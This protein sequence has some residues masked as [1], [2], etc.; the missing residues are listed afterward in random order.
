MSG[1]LGKL[2]TN[3][4]QR[5]RK[6]SF[7]FYLWA[8]LAYALG[9]FLMTLLIKVAFSG[10]ELTQQAVHNGQRAVITIASGTVEGG[11]LPASNVVNPETH[12]Q[13]VKTLP[14]APQTPDKQG[15]MPVPLESLVEM[16]DKGALPIVGPDGT[17]PWKYYSRPA[18]VKAQ[19]PMVAIVF[20]NL[21]L[22]ESQTQ[23]VLKLPPEFT[24]G[25]SPYAN[26]SGKIAFRARRDGFESV[27]DLPIQTFDYPFSDPGMFGLMEDLSP[28]ENIRRLHQVL[29]QF[30]GY[31]GM[32]ASVGETMTSNKEEIKPYLVELKKRGLLFLYVKTQ[33]NSDL[34][35]F[36][37]INGFY[38]LGIDELIDA[39]PS[40][41][42][43][44][45]HLQTL[46]DTAK[47]QGYAVGLVHS[48]PPTTAA[49][50]AWVDSLQ[51]QGVVLVPVSTIA[52]KVLP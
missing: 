25:F 7:A 41:G 52:K 20:T 34:E 18:G 10:R 26:D 32:L 42:Y 5:P 23:D 16:T 33:K 51:G 38:T 39:T 15:M 17:Q 46:V 36:A 28:D 24:L 14:S 3:G 31:I 11:G 48:Y 43:I 44:E 12:T 30:P 37:K 2:R 13:P 19:L 6:F 8:A 4:T 45:N 40:K 47:K 29:Y 21:G 35:D 49:L 50:S 1:I 27:V 9:I 22:N